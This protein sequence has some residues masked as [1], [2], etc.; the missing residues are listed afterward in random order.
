MVYNNGSNTSNTSQMLFIINGGAS[1]Y[2]SMDTILDC[3]NEYNNE[4]NMVIY[5]DERYR[6]RKRGIKSG[7]FLES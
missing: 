2:R 6:E 4:Y 7:V 1:Y 3:A 5:T